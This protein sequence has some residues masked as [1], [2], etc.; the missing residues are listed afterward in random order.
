MSTKEQKLDTKIDEM[1]TSSVENFIREL[2]EKEKD[3]DISSD[4][5]IEVDQSD[6]DFNSLKDELFFV[7]EEAHESSNEPRGL[8]NV[9]EFSSE[10][11]NPSN[12]EPA[13]KAELQ[14]LKDHIQKLTDEKRELADALVR[15]QRDFDS[16]K[17]RTE[18]ERSET[19]R[20]FVV[21]IG[22]EMLPVLDNL[23]RALNSYSVSDESPSNPDVENL[24]AGIVLVSQQLNDVISNMG[25]NQIPAVGKPFD[26]RFHEAVESIENEDVESDTV[27]EEIL[28]GYIVD[29]KVIRASMVVVSAPKRPERKP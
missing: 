14:T 20:N 2:E 13:N 12:E 17:N 18:R 22:T 23:D 9:V 7:E 21:T 15:R 10:P 28:K 6:V 29:S 5:V 27:I 26:P 1:D 25:I 11:A 3:L 4:L 16:H 24:I 8:G 19:F